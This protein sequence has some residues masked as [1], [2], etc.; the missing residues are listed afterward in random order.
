MLPAAS[1]IK[2]HERFLDTAIAPLCK[3]C[4]RRRPQIG[5]HLQSRDS[6][7][8]TARCSVCEQHP[9][10]FTYKNNNDPSPPPASADRPLYCGQDQCRKWYNELC[11]QASLTEELLVTKYRTFLIMRRMPHRHLRYRGHTIAF[12]QVRLPL[13]ALL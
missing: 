4:H 8:V 2:L 5:F 6:S 10:A 7:E 3:A 12:M 11:R 13:P 1:Q 9:G